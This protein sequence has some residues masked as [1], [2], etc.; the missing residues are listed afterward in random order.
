VKPLPLYL[1]IGTV[2]SVFTL[3]LLALPR[4]PATFAVA[5]VG[6]NVVQALSFTAAVAIC[7][8]VIGRNNALAATQF[9]LLTAMTVIPIVYMGRLDGRVYS[10]AWSGHRALRGMTGTML[11]DGGLSLAACVVMYAAMQRLARRTRLAGTA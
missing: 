3:L 4:T 8:E 9:G 10:M 2:G 6:E 5:F 11:V 1:L 7:F